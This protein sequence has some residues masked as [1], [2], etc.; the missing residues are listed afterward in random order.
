MKKSTYPKADDTI[1]RLR[2]QINLEENRGKL[3]ALVSQLQIAL[4]EEHQA[5][6][7]TITAHPRPEEN[8]FDTVILG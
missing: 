3:R 1:C 2:Q 5:M 4:N 6:L 8:P 7:A